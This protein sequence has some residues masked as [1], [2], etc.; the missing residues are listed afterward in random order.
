[1]SKMRVFAVM[2]TIDDLGEASGIE[3]AEL[4]TKKTKEPVAHSSVYL[5]LS[6]LRQKKHIK[7]AGVEQGR[8]AAGRPGRPRVIYALTRIGK[9]R[10]EN[11]KELVA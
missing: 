11:M 3:I 8:G 9:I 2:K 5:T 4:L 7:L 1:M 10:L 6:R